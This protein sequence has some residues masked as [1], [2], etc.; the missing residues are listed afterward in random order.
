MNTAK[1]LAKRADYRTSHI[2]HLLLSV[3]TAGLWL[4]VW[5]LVAVSNGM[6]RGKIDRELAKAE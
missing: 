4:P 3:V 6:E 2:L 1:L 5:V